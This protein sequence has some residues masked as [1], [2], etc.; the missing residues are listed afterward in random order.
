[1]NLIGHVTQVAGR[2]MFTCIE[3]D[4][5][6]SFWLKDFMAAQIRKIIAEGK[7]WPDT[8][9]FKLEVRYHTWPMGW[10]KD[11]YVSYADSAEELQRLLDEQREWASSEDNQVKIEVYEWDLGPYFHSSHQFG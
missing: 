11:T 2:S 5:P 10:D 8:A 9:V 1:M 7:G 4:I 3:N 6:R